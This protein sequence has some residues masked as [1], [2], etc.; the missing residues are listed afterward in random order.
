MVPLEGQ[1]EVALEEMLPTMS[2]RASGLVR[3]HPKLTMDWV[4]VKNRVVL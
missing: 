3:E 2:F 4:A 1:K